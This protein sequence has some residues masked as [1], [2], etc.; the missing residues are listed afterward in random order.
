M[1]H[2]GEIN[3]MRG[4]AHW[5]KARQRLLGTGVLGKELEKV[6]PIIREDGSDSAMFDTAWSS[7]SSRAARCTTRS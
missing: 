2:N 1:C 4:N 3:T 6:L 5:M 7:S